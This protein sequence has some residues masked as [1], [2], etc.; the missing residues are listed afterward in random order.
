MP[1]TGLP[2]ALEALLITCIDEFELHNWHITNTKNGCML[3]L[4]FSSDGHWNTG[5]PQVKTATYKKKSPSQEK[6]DS[7]RIKT[8]KSQKSGYGMVTRSKNKQPEVARKDNEAVHKQFDNSP[9]SVDS[10]VS[11]DAHCSPAINDSNSDVTIRSVNSSLHLKQDILNASYGNCEEPLFLGAH[12][13]S[14]LNL[15]DLSLPESEPTEIGDLEL[16]SDNRN[17]MAL[18]TAQIQ[19]LHSMQFLTNLD[20][21][22]S[23]DMKPV[24]DRAD[25]CSDLNCHFTKLHPEVTPTFGPGTMYKCNECGIQLCNFCL[26]MTMKT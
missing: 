19:D 9:V 18:E 3:K 1:V 5:E 8:F 23:C 12:S 20:Q 21:N 15:Q 16:D 25:N 13:N 11:V 24:D 4:N 7:S 2:K 6:R 10:V 14:D 17:N 26:Y 22:S